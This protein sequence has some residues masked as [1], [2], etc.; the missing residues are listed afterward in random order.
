VALRS[1]LAVLE[2]DADGGSLDA[3]LAAGVMQW[4]ARW[5]RR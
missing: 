1:A 2:L 5:G 3:L 4:R